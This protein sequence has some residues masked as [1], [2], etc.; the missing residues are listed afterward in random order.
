MSTLSKK[1][2]IDLDHHVASSDAEACAR[3]ALRQIKDL[4]KSSLVEVAAEY[5]YKLG[6]LNASG[7]KTMSDFKNYGSTYSH[8]PYDPK[9][10]SSK[11]VAPDREINVILPS[12]LKYQISMDVDTPALIAFPFMSIRAKIRAMA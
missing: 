7:V 10:A 12:G 11:D 3:I 6:L 4:N 5:G 8:G 2:D 1:F 9:S